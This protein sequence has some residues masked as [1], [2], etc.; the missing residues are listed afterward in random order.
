MNVKYLT[1]IISSMLSFAS[2]SQN[3]L[4]FNEL[5]ACIKQAESPMV[6]E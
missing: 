2:H 3:D 1:I 6:L 4:R 5:V